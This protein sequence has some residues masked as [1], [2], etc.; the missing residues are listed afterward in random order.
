MTIMSNNHDLY[1]ALDLGSNSFHLLVARFQDGKLHIVDRYKDM[2]RLAAGLDADN[3]LSHSAQETAL[4]SLEKMANRLEGVPKNQIRVVGTNTLRIA[5]NASEFMR[6]AEA[7]LGVAINIISGTEEARLV[8]LG[9]TKDFTPNEN[10]RLV[11]DIGGG[12]TEVVCGNQEPQFLESLEIG[13]VS[14]SKQYFNNNEISSKRFN[15]AQKAARQHIAPYVT[16]FSKQWDEAVGA[17][18]TI[19]SIGAIV[20]AMQ[21]GDAGYITAD[22]MEEIKALL[23]SVNKTE[24]LQI[25]GLSDERRDVFPGGFA[26]LYGLF[27]E[28]GITAMHVSN[29]AV[30]EGVIYDLV[31][32]ISQHHDKREQ[33]IQQ[34]IK[35]YHIDSGH[36]DRIATLCLQWLP[37]ITKYC[38]TP[39]EEAESL[40][41]WAAQLHELGIAI[42]HGAYHKHGAYVLSNADMPGFSRQEQARLSFLVLNHRRK[43]KPATVL[44][45]GVEADWL[46]VGALRIACV[47]Y[48]RRQASPLHEVVQLKAKNPQSLQLSVDADWLEANPL[49]AADLE[50]E[51]D[52][53]RKGANIKLSIRRRS[54]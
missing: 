38:L 1:A 10:R 53:L 54:N 41:R 11:I 19:R 46:L 34:L 28:L 50:D 43:P 7:T 9:T 44:P 21:L 18:G 4:R 48:R 27:Q 5:E 13:C 40:I 25:P 12:S 20:E 47:C 42:A 36:G 3:V 8:Y 23:L 52:F 29:Y 22:N 15:K 30:R 14:T 39:T 24:S 31:G 6:L 35:Q 26:V 17:S 37:N 2:L 16:Q 32:R 49:T 45:Y 51:I 33:T